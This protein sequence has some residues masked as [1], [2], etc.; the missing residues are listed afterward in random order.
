MTHPIP[1]EAEIETYLRRW[2]EDNFQALKLEGGHRLSPD[3]KAI[4][5]NQV[6]FY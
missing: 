2:F 3:V 5:F 6:L 1:T 4:A